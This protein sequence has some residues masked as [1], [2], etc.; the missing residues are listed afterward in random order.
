MFY[1]PPIHK[2]IGSEIL[3]FSGGY[4][5]IKDMYLSFDRSGSDNYSTFT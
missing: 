1:A 3:G 5:S 4:L 2:T